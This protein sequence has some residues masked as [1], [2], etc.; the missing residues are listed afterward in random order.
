MSLPEKTFRVFLRALEPDDY[1]TTIDWRNDDEIW[2]MV[3]GRKYFV[4]AEFERRWIENIVTGNTDDI[5]LAVCTVAQAVHIGNVYLTNIDFFARN[6]T[7]AI[8]L[9]D[10]S[11]WNGGYGTE[12]MLLLLRHAFM[13]LGLERVEARA[14]RTNAASVRMLEKCGYKTEGLLRK[15]AFKN[16]ALVDV[17]IM[18]CLKDEFVEVWYRRS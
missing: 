5:R 16:G 18:S 11:Y 10:K 2:G 1:K 13:D 14:L 6:A 9:G 7:S 4:A 8:L 17:N 15:A 12:S 3:V